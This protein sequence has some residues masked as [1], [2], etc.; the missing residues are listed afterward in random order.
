MGK[1]AEIPKTLTAFREATR[2]LD[3][4]YARFPKSCGLS[5]AEYWSLLF[6]YEGVAIQSRLSDMLFI[7]RQTLNSAFKQ[8]RQKGLVRLEP[9]ENDQRSKQIFLTDS[10]K[11][12]VEE[13]VLQMHRVEE[14]AWE[15]MSGAEQAM[16]T[17]LIRKFSN[18]I[19]SEL[20]YSEK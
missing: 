1:D 18:L 8:L 13:N 4:V 11:R 9:Y 5:E 2:E 17:Q 12:F 10:G 14:K 6:I 15:Q 20:K 16:L 7:S 3:S 19:R